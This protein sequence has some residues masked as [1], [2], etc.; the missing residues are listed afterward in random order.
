LLTATSI[1]DLDKAIAIIWPKTT[2]FGDIAVFKVLTLNC[3]R[4][5]AVK[6]HIQV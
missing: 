2:F 5:N 1:V 3:L 6:D 4:G